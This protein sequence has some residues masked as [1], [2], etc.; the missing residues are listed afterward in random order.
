LPPPVRDR[1]IQLARA[2]HRSAAAYIEQLVER[3]LRERD[4]ADR[5]IR[6]HTA[7]GLPDQPAGTV[8]REAGET[9][10]RHARRSATLNALF[11]TT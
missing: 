9:P 5:I 6:V 7:Q 1:V 4:E 8:T 3:D 2:E 10:A 11:G